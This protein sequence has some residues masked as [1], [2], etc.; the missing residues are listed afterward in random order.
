MYDWGHDKRAIGLSEACSDYVGFFNDDDSYVI[1]YIE[2]M[3]QEA[4]AGADVVYC[5]WS[6]FADCG[7]HMGSSTSGNFIVQTPLGQGVGWTSREYVADG[8]FIN[9]LAQVAGWIVRVDDV[10]YFHN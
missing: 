3:M 5:A 9:R 8:E 1:D 4:E 7:F 10:L 2:R 6:G